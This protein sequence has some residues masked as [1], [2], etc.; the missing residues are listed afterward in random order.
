MD[1]PETIAAVDLG[2][3]SF[4]L[5]VARPQNGGFVV[6]DRL[7]EMVRLRAGLDR[8]RRLTG[9]ARARALDCLRRF[10]QRL[11]HLPP[12]SV[13]AVG[14]NTLRSTREPR[15]FLQEAEAALGHPIEVIAGIEE[16]RLIYQ[17]VSHAL[18]ENGRRR[19][20]IDIGGGSTELITGERYAPI[21]MESMEMGCVSMSARH[22]GGGA[23]DRETLR[24]AELGALMAIEPY[25]AD[26]LQLGWQEVIGASGTIRA[27]GRTLE[28]NGWAS[29]G[30]TLSGLERLL[31]AL[32]EAGH[33]DNLRLPGISER[34]RPVFP[35]GVA[36]LTALFRALNI[37]R[38]EV[39]TGALR[40][41]LL[42][43][44]MGRLR[45]EDV[46][47]GA[48]LGLA[49]RLGA[50]MLQSERVRQTALRL[51]EG[52]AADW[53][54][55]APEHAER[56]GW[57]AALHEVGLSLSHDQYHKHGAYI[58]EHANLAGF[59][60]EEQQ[61]LAT[62]VR[63]HRRKFPPGELKRL[64]EA[65]RQSAYRLTILLRIAALLHRSRVPMP[66]PPLGITAGAARLA[67]TFPEGWLGAHPL[68]AADLAQEAELLAAV[69]FELSFR[70]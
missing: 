70:G 48:V 10:G 11:R 7:R 21:H 55:E 34:R 1:L 17:G 8:D 14:T 32:S 38:M 62:L 46:R 51:L 12:G 47:N 6:V 66:L 54:L 24:S 56:L 28:E 60:R 39:S 41:G 23:I 53:D 29:D 68:T 64:P 43:D 40:E 35:G 3:N 31:Q 9:D 65:R 13:R 33:V 15:R 19:L 5:I 44:L 69:E 36:I 27:V 2:S 30:I 18:A 63:G 37:E 57:A 61:L 16:A 52:T 67:L 4:H 42:H 45:H 50:D 26:F 59:S 25:Q 22:F 49:E 20:V 58:I